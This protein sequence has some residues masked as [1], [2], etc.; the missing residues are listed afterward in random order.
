MQESRRVESADDGMIGTIAEWL[1]RPI[2]TGGLDEKEGEQRNE[3]C[4]LQI[5]VE[6]LGGR[7]DNYGQ[8]QAQSLGRAMSRVEGWSSSGERAQFTKYGRQ[9]VYQR[10]DG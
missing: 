4:L 1:E 8:V 9:R 2:N 5:W 3:T 7:S 6:C 10:V